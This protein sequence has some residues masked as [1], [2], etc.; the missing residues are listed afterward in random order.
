[1]WSASTGIE[2]SSHK[3]ESETC[4]GFGVLDKLW[5]CFFWNCVFDFNA[6]MV[7]SWYH[8]KSIFF[9]CKLLKIVPGGFVIN[10]VI[11]LFFCW[12][13]VVFGKHFLWPMLKNTDAYYILKTFLHRRLK[14]LRRLFHPL[15]SEMWSMLKNFASLL[16]PLPAGMWPMLQNSATLIAFL[17]PEVWSMLIYNDG[18]EQVTTMRFTLS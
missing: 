5:I 14:S 10:L 12:F 18:Y 6:R 11:I 9:D 4:K 16:H 8:C 2:E 1:M 13:R 3:A 17:P 7:N 15:P